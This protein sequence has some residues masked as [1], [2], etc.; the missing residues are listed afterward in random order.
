MRV[1]MRR[2]VGFQSR[3]Q[4]VEPRRAQADSSRSQS[5]GR[6]FRVATEERLRFSAAAVFP[7]AIA[8][9]GNRFNRTAATALLFNYVAPSDSA[10]EKLVD[11]TGFEPSVSGA[12]AV[13]DYSGVAA[14]RLPIHNALPMSV[15]SRSSVDRTDAYRRTGWRSLP[16]ELLFSNRTTL[17]QLVKTCGTLAV[18]PEAAGP[19]PVD[20]ANLL[21]IS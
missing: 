7:Q 21:T 16:P 3:S 17:N 14:R 5:S 2:W 19:S 1:R 9:D 8:F 15:R 18:T 12:D 20:P 10:D 11:Q 6:A 4:R 13:T